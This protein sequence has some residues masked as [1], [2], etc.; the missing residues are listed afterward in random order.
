MK[1]F[2]GLMLETQKED[3]TYQFNAP[4]GVQFQEVIEVLDLFRSMVDEMA[5]K[6]QEQE[7]QS[8]EVAEDNVAAAEIKEED[9]TTS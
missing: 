1:A 7:K 8:K 2:Y 9:G 4:I 3:R 5:K 6:G